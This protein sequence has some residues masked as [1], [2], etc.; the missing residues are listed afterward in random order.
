MAKRTCS[1]DGCLNPSRSRGMCPKHYQRWFDN[2]PK[3][4]RAPV[5]ARDFDAFYTKSHAYGCWTWNGPTNRGGYGLWGQKLAHRVSWTLA[6]G[7]IPDGLF[8]CHHCDNPPCVN[9]RHLYP[10]TASDNARD[11]VTRNRTSNGSVVKTHCPQGHEYAGGN[12]MTVNGWRKCR[13]CEL[14]RKRESERRRRSRRRPPAPG[15]D[16]ITTADAAAKYGVTIPTIHKWRRKGTFSEPI[17]H[18]AKCWW[19]KAELDAFVAERA[20]RGAS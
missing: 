18:Q 1:E 3:D 14:S 12:L 20:K 10:G 17:K 6:N 13:T 16:W 8:I 2:T 9:P 11:M 19:R 7:P 4:L 15:E 5:P